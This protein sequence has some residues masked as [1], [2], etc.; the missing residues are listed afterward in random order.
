MWCY[1][2]SYL[3]TPSLRITI[4]LVT[5]V[6]FRLKIGIYLVLIISKLSLKLA[7]AVVGVFTDTSNILYDHHHLHWPLT[8]IT[9]DL[10]GVE[11]DKKQLG[12]VHFRSRLKRPI[13][14]WHLR[15]H[16][17][18]MKD[19][20]NITINNNHSIFD[21]L[22]RFRPTTMRSRGS[23]RWRSTSTASPSAGYSRSPARSRRS[24]AITSRYDTHCAVN[25][26]STWS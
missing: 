22:P 23:C 5:C 17:V 1:Y 9:D 19:P 11:Q 16:F 24:V 20:G 2:K 12:I 25:C 3:Y 21:S 14:E 8:S 13:R 15:P 4:E 10:S 18:Q 7:L 26:N 6:Y